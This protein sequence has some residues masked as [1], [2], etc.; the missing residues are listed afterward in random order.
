M[1][2]N[3]LLK[4]ALREAVK[5]N[6]KQKM[7][8]IIYKNGKI[9]SR[10]YNK[11]NRGYSTYNQEYWKGSLHAE[12]S[13]ILNAKGKSLKGASI[14]VARANQRLAKPCKKCMAVIKEVGIKF[15][16]FTDRAIGDEQ[17]EP[18]FGGERVNVKGLI[19]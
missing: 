18:E 8:A 6:H 9:I 15:V 12:I 2:Y 16:G 5:G 3:S 14:F 7:G 1:K 19:K 11:V 17:W 13:A 10:G 4:L